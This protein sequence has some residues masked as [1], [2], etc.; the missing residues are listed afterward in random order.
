MVVTMV[1]DK[2]SIIAAIGLT[3]TACAL[4]MLKVALESII[5]HNKQ[6]RGM[7]LITA[8]LGLF[9]TSFAVIAKSA[10]LALQWLGK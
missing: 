8:A 1:L 7:L 4:V 3:G 9:V 2:A 6:K 5:L 10:G